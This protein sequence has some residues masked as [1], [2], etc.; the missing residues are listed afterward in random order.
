METTQVSEQIVH[1]SFR[2]PFSVLAVVTIVPLPVYLSCPFRALHAPGA[3]FS[4]GGLKD[5]KASKYLLPCALLTITM[6]G[7]L[8]ASAQA[9]PCAAITRN[10]QV[11]EALIDSHSSAEHTGSSAEDPSIRAADL[12]H[13]TFSPIVIQPGDAL[14][15][16]SRGKDFTITA[17]YANGDFADF[18]SSPKASNE[19]WR[20][21]VLPLDQ[22]SAAVGQRLIKLSATGRDPQ[23]VFFRNIRIIRAGRPIFEFAKLSSY[24]KPQVRNATQRQLPCKPFNGPKSLPTT[25]MQASYSGVPAAEA[26]AS[27]LNLSAQRS[28]PPLTLSAQQ[29]S[30]MRVDDPPMVRSGDEL[31]FEANRG[32]FVLHT[33]LSNGK[34]IVTQPLT[35]EDAENVSIAWRKGRTRLDYPETVNQQIVAFRLI[36]LHLSDTPV[37]FRNI[38]IYRQGRMVLELERSQPGVKPT[39]PEPPMSYPPDPRVLTASLGT[40]NLL[41]RESATGFIAPRLPAFSMQPFLMQSTGGTSGDPNHF[42]YAGQELD[43]ESGLY[44]MGARYYSPGL[45]RFTSPDP[46][47]IEMH[48]L[49]D[50]QQLNL[51][52]YARNNPTTFSDPTGLDVKLNCDTASNCNKAVQD[53]N[54]R[55]NAQFK[56]ELGKDGKIHAVKDSIGKNLSKAEGALLGA[57]NDTKNHA[58][59]NVSGDTGQSEFGQH[60]GRGVN[61][62]D[63]GNLSHLDGPS[64]AGGLNS[65]DAIAHEALDAYYSLSM[66]PLAADKAAFALFP[67]LSGP[68][69]NQNITNERGT[70]ITGSIFNQAITNGSGTERIT[71]QFITPVPAIDLFGRSPAAQNDITHDAG[72]RVTGVTFVPPKQQ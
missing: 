35:A 43:A 5:M 51:Y 34:E 57:I 72:S 37:M 27:V 47:Y 7:K 71:I 25:A 42:K 32:D 48:R 4:V 59:L 24:G 70:R 56:V 62:V 29:I 13:L 46:L 10:P 49:L 66:D 45:G 18:D 21:G 30:E 39:T 8:A 58:T 65:G 3:P 64:N 28:S 16:E 9:V 53:F 19:Q 61:S 2:L 41:G 1:S 52:A 67:G 68:T 38:K 31:D 6:L 11:L 63:L 50:P 40:P 36:P 44:H 54:G 22:F 17:R 26:V 69:D 12:N 20:K 14:Y 23:Q 33:Y 55:K 15:V 60:D